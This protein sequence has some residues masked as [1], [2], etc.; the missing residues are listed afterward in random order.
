MT[1]DSTELYVRFI[2]YNETSFLIRGCT[3]ACLRTPGKHPGI[4]DVFRKVKMYDPTELKTSFKSLG[5]ILS[6][7]QRFFEPPEI[8]L[9]ETLAQIG[10]K[11]LSTWET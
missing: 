2:K 1:S 4:R 7:G 9:P 11:Q 5:G 6:V 8:A 3:T 10:Q